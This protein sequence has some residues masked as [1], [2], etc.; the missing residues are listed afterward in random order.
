M[1]NIN[2]GIIGG[3][4]IAKLFAESINQSFRGKFVSIASKNLENRNYFLKNFGS[5]L[6][7]V[8]SY[9]DLLNDDSID[10]VYIAL[11]NS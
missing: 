1:K 11:I 6:K 5:D 10:V 8:D 9:D 7:I 3:G 4:Q 2:W